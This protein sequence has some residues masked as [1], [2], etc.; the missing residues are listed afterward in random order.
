MTDAVAPK[1][2]GARMVVFV[3]HCYDACTETEHYHNDESRYL[4]LSSFPQLARHEILRTHANG[5]RS[6]LF[7]LQEDS[8]HLLGQWLDA[9]TVQVDLPKER[10]TCALTPEGAQHTNE[11]ILR[12]IDNEGEGYLECVEE[13]NQFCGYEL[14][15]LGEDASIE[16]D[17]GNNSG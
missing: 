6:A 3:P 2:Q 16:V 15:M 8:E 10:V 9:S 5:L 12:E 13:L 14:L 17:Q 1:V 7:A 4:P 11:D